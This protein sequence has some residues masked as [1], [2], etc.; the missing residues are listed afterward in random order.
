M[1][2]DRPA[3]AN[4]YL[5]AALLTLTACGGG[6]GGGSASSEPPGQSPGTPPV[7]PDPVSAPN[8]Y[9]NEG[10]TRPSKLGRLVVFGDSY[11]NENNSLRPGVRVW[12]SRLGADATSIYAR[13]DATAGD[14]TAD[15]TANDF[16][17][18]VDR[19]LAA[20]LPQGA[21]DLVAVYLGYNDIQLTER[22]IASSLADYREELERLLDNGAGAGDRKVLVTLVHDWSQVPRELERVANGEAS[23]QDR[24]DRFNRGV[25]ALANANDDVIA[26]DLRTVFDRVAADP[27]RY[28]ITNITT[29][30]RDAADTTALYVDPIHF[31]NR[32][33]DIVAQVFRHYLTRGWS[34]A[35][36]LS[37]GAEA[38]ARLQQDIEQGLVF[39]LARQSDPA[40]LGFSTFAVGDGSSRANALAQE[41]AADPA[42]G[43]FAG[44][45]LMEESDSGLGLNYALD[46]DTMLGVVISD[47]REAEASRRP[48]ATSAASV[49]SAGVSV[50][51]RQNV[52]G[53]DLATTATVSDDR[54]RKLDH[55]GL[56]DEQTRV[57]FD[58]R[59]TALAATL[60]RPIR[61]GHGWLQPWL[62][63]TR[64]TQE[65]DGFEQPDPYV[66]DLR[67]SGAQV[68]DTLLRFG[69]GGRLDPLPVGDKGWLSLSGNLSYTHGLAQDDYT[70]RVRETGTGFEQEQTL[71]REP[72]RLLGLRLGADLELGPGLALGSSYQLGQQLGGASGHEVKAELRYSF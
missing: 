39:S 47:Y 16:R 4:G 37:A 18:Q 46:R 27:E 71:E 61:A 13:S 23:K 6:S 14:Q 42:R 2:I 8:P 45:R 1:T 72:T 53:F 33:Q 20:D 51:A 10:D 28:G 24:V 70:V 43:H 7:D 25:V 54:H 58:G 59:T 63:L 17:T 41:Q 11:S 19:W 56:L 55:D 67:F 36:S 68:T 60:S 48:L 57:A 22:D 40:P 34:W 12:S 65:V 30:D 3:R 31:G 21:S 44:T 9:A 66:S 32:G 62:N 38:T 5:L 69:L 50:Y 49:E 26:V 35:N 52:A 15:G 29:A 64:T